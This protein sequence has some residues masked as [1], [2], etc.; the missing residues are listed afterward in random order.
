[1]SD[2]AV[3]SAMSILRAARPEDVPAM[4]RVLKA[5]FPRWPAVDIGV[6]AE[7]HL[8]WKMEIGA[9]VDPARHSVIELDGQVVAVRLRWITRVE[10]GGTEYLADAGADVA[11]DPARQGYGL[12]RMLATQRDEQAAESRY[13]SFQ[14]PSRS[15]QL[16]HMN[17]VPEHILRPLGMWVRFFSPWEAAKADLRLR[18]FGALPG[19]VLRALRAR[20][21]SP[22]PRVGRVED[23]DHF[24]ARTDALWEKVRRSFGVARVRTAGYLNWRYADRRG[25]D[26]V[27]VAVLD[28]P[29]V[30]G[31]AVFRRSGDEAQVLDLVVD[32][33]HRDVGRDLLEAGCVRMRASGAR[34]VNCWLPPA[35][36]DEVSLRASGFVRAGT[37][38]LDFRRR[39]KAGP[40]A[41]VSV[42]E[43]PR[44]QM[45]ITMGDFD[46]V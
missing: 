36:A 41:A 26:S 1:M 14:T 21:T 44:T 12:G 35:H 29:S 8:R 25:G 28:G 40:P 23:L 27:I 16:L 46:F 37:G 34:R 32:A 38:T 19:H 45:H 18:M 42:I 15:P 10:V 43:D 31:F 33:D 5:A 9:E 6:T 13:V 11:V 20:A 22:E 17:D 2:A 3:R 30:L 4:V 39:D 24:D 7:E